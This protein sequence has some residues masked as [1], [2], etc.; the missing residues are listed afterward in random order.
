MSNLQGGPSCVCTFGLTKAARVILF[1][2]DNNHKQV[3]NQ[4]YFMQYIVLSF[5]ARAV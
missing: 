2:K 3:L 1:K 4:I 5:S